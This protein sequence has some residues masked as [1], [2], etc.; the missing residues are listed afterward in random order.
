MIEGGCHCGAL[1]YRIDAEASDAGYCH[2]SICRETTGAPV[3]VWA[4]FPLDAFEYA[5]G[6][7]RVYY[8]SEWG[9]REFCGECGT[10]I[11]YR[12]IE[13]AVNIDINIGSLD[14]PDDIEPECHIYVADQLDWFETDDDLPRF[15]EGRPGDAE[16]ENE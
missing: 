4:T 16:A 6:E 14:E 3:L 8:S 13:D 9:Q 10:Q 12:E 11:G 5:G 7:P 1:R 2:C 15:E